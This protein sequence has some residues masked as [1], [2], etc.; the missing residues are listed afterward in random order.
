MSGHAAAA[1]RPTPLGGWI[2]LVVLWVVWGTSWPAMRTVFAE[3]P[4]WQFRSI[5]CLTGGVVLLALTRAIEGRVW[6]ARGEWLPLALCAFFNMTVWH[7]ASGYGLRMIGAGH[8]AVVC[9]TLPVWTALLSA[10]FLKERL[11]ARVFVSLVCGMG[12]VAVLA[13]HDFAALGSNPLGPL[14][15]LFSAMCWAVEIGRASCRERV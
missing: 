3:M 10:L 15:V 13:S 1:A 8:A 4:V 14:V 6:L 12:G 5:T 7:V 11:T 9:Y 2:A